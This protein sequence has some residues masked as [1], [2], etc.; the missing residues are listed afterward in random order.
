MIA[1]E[2]VVPRRPIDEDGG[3]VGQEREAL[4]DH[5][6]VAAQHAL[7]VDDALGHAGR[8]RGEQ[9]FRNRVRADLGGGDVD[10]VAV[11]SEQLGE[12]GRVP[13]DG[14]V[15]D[16]DQFRRARDDGLDRAGVLQAVIGEDEAG[17]R[18]LDDVAQLGEIGRDQRVGDRDGREGDAHMQ[19]R[20]RQQGVLD[21]VAA[22][23]RDGPVWREIAREQGHADAAD[24]RIGLG[25]GDAAPIAAPLAASE[26]DPVGGDACPV[27]QP[28]GQPVRIG[29]ERLRR[30]REQA[31]I[32]AFGEHGVE[33]SEADRARFGGGAHRCTTF[34]ARFSRKS[35]RRFLASS[36]PCA[37]AAIR[38]SI[39]SP[40]SGAAVAMRGSA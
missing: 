10:R 33:R 9:Q 32:S 37:I 15:R 19:R 38:L 30:A 18:E 39:S 5:L 7:R 26:I 36:D 16:D 1:A 35:A 14:Q 20:Q 25:V 34:A 27:F 22:Q 28:F 12:V 13:A 2:G 21:G 6:L 8:A 40:V 29:A 31:T 17:R 24:L 4:G 23:D 3:L 11:G